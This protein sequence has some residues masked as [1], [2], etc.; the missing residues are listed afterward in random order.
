MNILS[1][2]WLQVGDDRKSVNIQVIP[3]AGD[4]SLTPVLPDKSPQTIGSYLILWPTYLKSFQYL[5]EN[6]A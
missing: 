3:T 5:G 1:G 6:A 2:E 4:S